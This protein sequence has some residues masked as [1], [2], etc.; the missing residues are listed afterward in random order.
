MKKILNKTFIIRILIIASLLIVLGLILSNK[1]NVKSFKL[2]Q[3]SVW[4][5]KEL[6]GD[7]DV[8]NKIEAIIIEKNNDKLTIIKENNN[9]YILEKDRYPALLLKVKELMFGLLDLKIIDP[10]TNNPEHF[11]SMDLNNI[12]SE[13]NAV[14]LT[15][16]DQDRNELDSIYLGKREF[17]ATPN[18]NYQHYIFV[19]RPKEQQTWLVAGNMPEGLGFKDLVKQPLINVDVGKISAV[20]LIKTKD[21]KNYIYIKRNLSNNDLKLSEIPKGFKIKDDYVV[22]NILQQFSYLSYDDVVKDPGDPKSV[23]SGEITVLAIG[24]QSNV[25]EQNNLTKNVNTKIR[26]ETIKFEMVYLNNCYYFKLI[27]NQENQK[28]SNKW[29]Y[30]ISDY[31]SQSLLINKSDLLDKV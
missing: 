3:K 15:L 21:P 22:D 20:K 13:S 7:K 18:A 8:L 28:E 2:S 24:N 14:K 25:N 9:W 31:S 30:K 23:L 11:A 27:A 6:H 1:I 5:L 19:R 26:E 12:G 17:I 4:F 10:K 29:L 16:L